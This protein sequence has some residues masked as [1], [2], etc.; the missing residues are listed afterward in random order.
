MIHENET[1]DATKAYQTFKETGWL[2]VITSTP[3]DYHL[4]AL[5]QAGK[6]QN[7]TLQELLSNAEKIERWLMEPEIKMQEAKKQINELFN[8][9]SSDFKKRK[10]FSE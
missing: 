8:N 10:N 2:P 6:L 1:T 4:I 5:E 3:P 9:I 7:Q